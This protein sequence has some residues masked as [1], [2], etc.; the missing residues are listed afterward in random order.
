MAQS[1]WYT[2][3]VFRLKLDIKQRN[4]L[5]TVIILLYN[6]LNRLYTLKERN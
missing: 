6:Y 5:N 3:L 4:F 1:N 2:K